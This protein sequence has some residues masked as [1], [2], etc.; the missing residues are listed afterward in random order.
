MK[1]LRSS[2]QLARLGW[3]VFLTPGHKAWHN[4]LLKPFF[5]ASQWHLCR[6]KREPLSNVEQPGKPCVCG[7]LVSGEAL[8]FV[9]SVMWS[10]LRSLFL[11]FSP[12]FLSSLSALAHT[13][14]LSL[15]LSK[16]PVT[17]LSL[18]HG[19][20]QEEEASIYS[21][22]S[23]IFVFAVQR[24]QSFVWSK[25]ELWARQTDVQRN[26]GPNQT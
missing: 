14:G 16:R 6:G 11:F 4:P 3:E 19:C 18:L 17:L 21:S 5:V 10:I 12:S 1:W 13:G 23:V 7:A 25:S 15:A 24:I 9:G 8:P 26:T 22:E 20:L 2:A